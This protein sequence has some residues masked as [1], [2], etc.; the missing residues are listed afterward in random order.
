MLTLSVAVP[1]L[2][3]ADMVNKTVAESEHSPV[4]CPGGHDHSVCTQ[5]GANLSAVS[6]GSAQELSDASVYI[7]LPTQEPLIG[8]G[9]FTE[10][11]PPRA[12]P[13]A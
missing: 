10:G 13:L 5:V 7:V 11:P 9:A 6:G 4:E 8:S 1:L 12:P 3:R 2:G